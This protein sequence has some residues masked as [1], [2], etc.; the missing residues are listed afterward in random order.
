M[1]SCKVALNLKLHVSVMWKNIVFLVCHVL[2]ME[3]CLTFCQNG[4]VHFYIR[5]YCNNIVV[6]F[7]AENIIIEQ[8]SERVMK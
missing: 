5:K 7:V 2:K 1:L 6:S 4:F 8:R 3:T